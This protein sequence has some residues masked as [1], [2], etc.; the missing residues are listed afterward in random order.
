MEEPIVLREHFEKGMTTSNYKAFF[1]RQKNIAHIVP[2]QIT[3]FISQLD[4]HIIKEQRLF[5]KNNLNRDHYK[6][7]SR[8]EKEMYSSDTFMQ[9]TINLYASDLQEII[10]DLIQ[11]S[12]LKAQQLDST[13]PTRLIAQEEKINKE[14]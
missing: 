7:R 12:L 1:E 13:Y 6:F 4:V 11:E 2:D 3:D 14:D 8:R 9:K 10:E 5:K